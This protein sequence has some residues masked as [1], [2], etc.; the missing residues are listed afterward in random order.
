MLSIN[1]KYKIKVIPKKEKVDNNDKEEDIQYNKNM[2]NGKGI[3]ELISRV[4]DLKLKQI[5]KKVNK[6]KKISF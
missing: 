6:Y 1:P 4:K 3:N 5:N 2:M